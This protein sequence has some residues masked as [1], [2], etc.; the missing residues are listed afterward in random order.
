MTNWYNSKK[1]EGPGFK[2]GDLVMLDSRYIR[3]KRPSKKLDY[4]KMGPFCIE[5]AIGNTAFR[6]ELPLQMKV[7]PVYH[8]G[9]L[10]YYRDSK[11]PTRIQ[12]VPEVEEID[13][14][15]NWEV[16]EIVDSRQNRRKKHNP[17][18]YLFLWEVYPDEDGTS[19]VYDNLKGTADE[20]LQAFHRRY[21]KAV[22]D[23]RLNV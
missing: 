7:H 10:E 23:R 22:K 20:L 12:I 4:K 19:E 1:Q 21:P 13:G 6:L 17:I 3:P 14:E 18:E 16:R 5:K 11:D 2:K 15:L 8:I 9:W